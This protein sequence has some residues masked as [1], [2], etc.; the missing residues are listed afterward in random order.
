MTGYASVKVEIDEEG[1][2]L[3]FNGDVRAG[4]I[5]REAAN[6]LAAAIAEEQA[7]PE[8]ERKPIKLEEFLP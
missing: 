5:S 6:G 3:I 2:W 7:K 4:P 8:A 1:L